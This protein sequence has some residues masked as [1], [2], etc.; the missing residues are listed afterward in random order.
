V[1]LSVKLLVLGMLLERDRHPYDI[2]QTIKER[3]WNETF[4]IRD[5]SLYYAFDQ[6]KADGWIETAEVIPV[7][8]EHRPDKTVYR[9]TEKGRQAFL[10]LLYGQLEQSQQ[11]PGHS[12]FPA[13]PFV[14]HADIGRVRQAVARRLEACEARIE[15]LR[16][17]IEWK[18]S[19]LPRGAYHLL[20]GIL[21]FV[22]AEREWLRDVLADAE[23]GALGDPDWSPER[24]A[25]MRRRLARDSE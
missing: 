13:L 11:Y 22:E 24:I 4:N 5:G 6:M 2:R 10:D 20:K 16:R 14:R 15:R 23:S 7:P 1:P 21:R 3:N 18:Q 17:V 12:L 8:G 19:Y 9:I 25:E